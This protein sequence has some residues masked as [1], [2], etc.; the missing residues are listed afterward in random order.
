MQGYTAETDLPKKTN[1][2]TTWK[3]VSMYAL[4]RKEICLFLGHTSTGLQKLT[5][6]VYSEESSF[7]QVFALLG[8]VLS[9]VP[10]IFPGH[11]FIGM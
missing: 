7:E 3:L 6:E 4:T 8:C 10:H 5:E 1:E 2:K 9:S 11:P